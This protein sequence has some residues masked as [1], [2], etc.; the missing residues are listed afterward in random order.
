MAGRPSGI[1]ATTFV[2]QLD[3]LAQI[4]VPES[5]EPNFDSDTDLNRARQAPF[6]MFQ[7]QIR[8]SN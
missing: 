6:E 5:R 3:S 8:I 2:L 4:I 1:P 7:L